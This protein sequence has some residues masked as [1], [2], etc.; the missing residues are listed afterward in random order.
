MRAGRISV[1]LRSGAGER[2]VRYLVKVGRQDPRIPGS[3]PA[4]LAG[5]KCGP[6]G[7]VAGEWLLGCPQDG[8]VVA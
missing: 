5:V 3:E 7:K 6:A 2:A 1:R 8:L 4:S